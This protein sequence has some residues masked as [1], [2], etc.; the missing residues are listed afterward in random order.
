MFLLTPF[1]TDQ[2]LSRAVIQDHLTQAHMSRTP[3][4]KTAPLSLAQQR[5]WLHAQATPDVPLYNHTVCVCTSEALSLRAVERS[6]NEIIRR[7]ES[8]RTNFAVV[9]GQLTAI[10]GDSRG[11]VVET[12][13]QR[14]VPGAEGMV[15]DAI[16]EK[17]RRAFDLER[18]RPVKALLVRLDTGDRLY[19]ILHGIAVDEDSVRIW[20]S[21]FSA[22]YEAF[23]LGA[24]SPLPEL[25]LQYADFAERQTQLFKQGLPSNRLTYWRRQ[26]GGEL[27]VLQLPTDRPRPVIRKLRGASKRF[28]ISQHVQE[29]LN[30]LSL[31]E[32]SALFETLLTAVLALLHRYT[33]Q[34]DI[35]VGGV[36]SE[37]DRPELAGLLGC[38]ED[39]IPLRAD[40][41]GNPRFCELLQKVKNTVRE[42]VAHRIPFA[43]LTNELQ[44]EPDHSRSPFFDVML[45][46]LPKSGP[47]NGLRLSQWDVDPSTTDMDLSFEIEESA[48]GLCCRVTYDNDLFDALTIDQMS[49]HFNNLLQGIAQDSGL[50]VSE[51]SLLT[52]RE[53]V[54]ILTHWN[55][56][57]IEY[58]SERCVHELVQEQAERRPRSVAVIQGERHLTFREL[59]GR[60]NQLARFLLKRG[61]GPE[62]FVGICLEPSFDLAISLLAI[63]KAGGACVPLDP[64]YPA[65]RL[66]HMLD[67]TRAP[68]ILTNQRMMSQMGHRGADVIDLEGWWP[69]IEEESRENPDSQTT[70]EN[71][72]YVIYTS[73]STGK[74]RGVLLTHAGFVNHHLAAQKIYGLQAS[75]RVLQ[76]S[77]ISFDIAVEEIFPTWISGATLVLRTEETPLAVP[78]FLEWIG[79]QG[80]TVLDLPTAYWHEMVYQLMQTKGSLPP[81]LRLTIVGGEKALSK[82]LSAWTGLAAGRVRWINTYGPSEASVIATA[83]EP[84]PGDQVPLVLPIGRPIDNT[85]IYLLDRYMNPVPVG[86]TGEL[87]IGGVGVARGYLN[88]PELTAERFLPDPFSDEAWARL[89]RT[90]DLARYLPSGEIEFLGRRDEQVKIRGFRVEAGEVEAALG[91]YANI[92]ECVVVARQVADGQKQLIAYVVPTRDPAPTSNEL[93]GFLQ[94]KLPDYMVPSAFVILSALPLT[95]NGKVNKKALPDPQEPQG[96]LNR[97]GKT[98]RDASQAQLLQIWEEVLSKKPIGIDQNFFELGGHS[99]LAVRLMYRVEQTFSKRLPI[100]A[101][102]QAPTVEKLA[103]LLRQEDCSQAWS[104][105]V[106]IQTAG[107]RPP[108]FCVHGIGGTVLRFRDLARLVAPDQPFYGLQAQGLDGL[109]SPY[110]KVEDMAQH[111]L[112]EIRTL[113]PEGPYYLGGYSFGGTVALE[114]ARMLQA[115]RHEVGLLVLI[116][117]VPGRLK[118]AGSLVQKY[119]RLPADQKVL[120]LVRKIRA[121]KKSLRRRIAM[122]MLPSNLKKVKAACYIAARNYTPHSYHGP[123]VLIQASEKTLGNLNEQAGWLELAPQVKIHEVIGHHGNIVDEPQVRDLANLLQECLDAAQAD[124]ERMKAQ[125]PI[126]SVA[127]ARTECELSDLRPVG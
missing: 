114:I 45:K 74:P 100:T 5:I 99:L 10:V 41:S 68:L 108:F 21:E 58:P 70:P 26:L 113:Q 46:L 42:S 75:D 43:L 117:T 1:Q 48:D 90:G 6:L 50:R 77:S 97:I 7:H 62:T 51:L 106:P 54:Q 112:K 49:D 31:R 76:F 37:R 20:F 52:D 8:W 91:Q 122:L 93:R 120:H 2:I 24:P 23:S 83:Y 17:S 71:L 104:S 92:R 127:D 94:S 18:E 118:T 85:R 72:A 69:L 116:D 59:N 19:L 16:A 109:R 111:Y 9:E 101:L 61:V 102:F 38:F 87:Y 126:T 22:L 15:L 103:G 67:D 124:S 35:V 96:G 115:E 119:L 60:A 73:G 98:P 25:P 65:E 27:P 28:C 12:I 56:T 80:V 88:R 84:K 105:L 66:A 36:F 53:Q 14:G 110:T 32:E 34:D 29:S 11:G 123:V 55:D 44:H 47:Q 125:F 63:L 30:G 107:S 95:H 89:Y 57:A 81:G 121:V 82:A 13:D 40:L 78:A 64:N 79:E 4:G 86:V 39:R 3:R 33:D